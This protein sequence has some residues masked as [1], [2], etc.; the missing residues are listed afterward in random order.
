MSANSGNQTNGDP[1]CPHC[2][3]SK[4][5]GSSPKARKNC[6]SGANFP[7]APGAST[8]TAENQRRQ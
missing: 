2:H 4:L 7:P 1:N 5:H 6:K 8:K 3:G